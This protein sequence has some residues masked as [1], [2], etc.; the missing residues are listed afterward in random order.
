MALFCSLGAAVLILAAVGAILGRGIFGAPPGEPGGGGIRAGGRDSAASASGPAVPAPAVPVPAATSASATSAGREPVDDPANLSDHLGARMHVVFSTDCGSFQHWQ[1]YLLFYSALRVGQPGHVTRIA[2]GCH[3][4]EEERALA[5]FEEHVR[6][7]APGRFHLHLTPAFSG[8]KGED[9]RETGKSYK[10]FNKPFGLR[11][12]LEHA[13]GMG[14]DAD[15]GLPTDPDVVVAL[16][17][18]DMIFLRRMTSDYGVD[19]ETVLGFLPKKAA[20]RGD[21]YLRVEPGKPI[22]ATYGFGNQWRSKVDLAL[23]PGVGSDSPA[24]K[25]SDEFARQHFS[26]GP[27]YLAVASDMHRI[28]VGWTE[29][30]PHVHEQYPKLLAEMFGFCISAA[31]NE[32]PHQRIDSFMVSDVTMAGG[33]EGWELIDAIPPEEVCGFASRPDHDRYA[34]PNVV[35][36]CQRYGIGP[37]WFSKRQVPHGIFT[38]ESPLLAAPPAN[39]AERYDYRTSPHGERQEL[40]E[41]RRRSNEAFVACTMI[42][43][44][45]EASGYFKRHHCGKEANWESSLYLGQGKVQ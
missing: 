28:A 13:E 5:W 44:I 2:S 43:A 30:V 37:Y 3:P 36:Y 27:P 22:A 1:S 20:E 25:G 45:N 18:P 35:H 8:V 11:H 23:I 31:H 39:A 16:I 7:M 38:C 32:L 21:R 12:W 15:T 34:L 40:E 42:A 14:L 4:D 6:P 17:D 33:G 26:V 10:Y 29:F 19:R 41:G 24:L 9:G